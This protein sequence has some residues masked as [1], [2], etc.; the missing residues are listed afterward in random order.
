LAAKRQQLH[1]T[2]PR[3]ADSI[4]ENALRQMSGDAIEQAAAGPTREQLADE[5][6][7]LEVMVE[8]QE[9]ILSQ[10]VGK[11][12]REIAAGVRPAYE[13]IVQRLAAAVK[14]AAA[15]AAEEIALRDRLSLAG[16][17][18]APVIPS[19]GIDWLNLSD[20]NSGVNHWLAEARE[21][22]KGV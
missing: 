20:P 16:V 18:M 9:K 10:L 1:A 22:Y 2:K 15:V 17:S 14:D 7:T 5:C 4:H 19:V 13:A 3:R 21:N 11:V 8:L 12:G 6:R